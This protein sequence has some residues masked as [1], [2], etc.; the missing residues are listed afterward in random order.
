MGRSPRHRQPNPRSLSDCLT[1]RAASPAPSKNW[2]VPI[3]QSLHGRTCHIEHSG[4]RERRTRESDSRH[5]RVMDFERAL[6]H[7]DP[8]HQQVLLLTYRDGLRHSQAA[9]ML[10][11]SVRAVYYLLP[12][13]RRRLA[14]TL[15]R[16]DL[17]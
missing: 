8:A 12:A 17:L 15:D 3:R 5:V 13:A 1:T 7:L 16:L 6:A 2:I 4:W 14:D 11:C 9:S 10:G